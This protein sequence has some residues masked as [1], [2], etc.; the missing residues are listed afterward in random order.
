MPLFIQEL[1]GLE[2]LKGSAFSGAFGRYLSPFSLSHPFARVTGLAR[3][4]Q[5]SSNRKLGGIMA[6]KKWHR[7]RHARNQKNPDFTRSSGKLSLSKKL[8]CINE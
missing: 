7:F 1:P 8:Y 5:A 3:R 6:T 2:C 4:E